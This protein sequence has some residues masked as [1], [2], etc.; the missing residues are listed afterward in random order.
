MAKV[1]IKKEQLDFLDWEFGVFFHFGIRTFYEGHRDWDGLP[2]PLEGFNPPQIDCENWIQTVKEAGAKYAILVCKHHDGFANWPTN[3]TDYS[4]K[5]T[6]W[7]DGKGDVVQEFVD[8]CRKYDIK[9][10]LYYSPAQ[11]GSKDMDGKEYDDYFI[12]Q[13]S[14]LL[15]N[16]GKIDYLWFD[17]CGSE[18]HN[19]DTVRIVKEIR[20][21]QPDILIFNMWDPDTRWIGNEAGIAP[22]FNKNMLSQLSGFSINKAEGDELEEVR[23]LPGE[24]DV[25]I[26]ESNWFYADADA[27][28]L[29]S[30]DELMALYYTSVG[31]GANLLLNVAPGRDGRLPENDAKRLLE[32]GETIR[33]TFSEE[34][35]ISCE[36]TQE[37]N[38][39]IIDF[40]GY[41]KIN[42][43]VLSEEIS[44]ENEIES[45]DIKVRALPWGEAISTYLGHTV[46]HKK[47][48]V[49][50][51]ACARGMEITFDKAK[52]VKAEVYY[53]PAF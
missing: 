15:T 36:C 23:F 20:K 1:N 30:L 26:R 29:K 48:C 33:K 8:A 39:L 22:V 10:G 46:G 12:N 41:R 9:V 37:D 3:Y 21:C 27:H 44:D 5:N 18:G 42:H 6:P 38:K 11:Q 25:T 17:G 32:L 40:G 35:K 45:F 49:F 7:K 51:T 19:Y 53:V 43:I 47:I 50:P 34:N 4:V 13:I 2:M 28:T 16:Y 24:C 31:R 14:E 52:K